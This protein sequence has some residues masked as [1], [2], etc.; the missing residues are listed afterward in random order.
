MKQWTI[1]RHIHDESGRSYIGLTVQTME[2]RWK[3]HICAAKS[4]KGGRWHFPNAI[5]KYG[6][7]AFSHEILQICYSLEEANTAEKFWIWTYDTQNVLR[8][9]NLAKGGDHIPHPIRKNPWNDPEFR[10]KCGANW[11]HLHTPQAKAAWKASVNT[12]ESRAKR[13][14]ISKEALSRPEVLAKISAAAKQTASTK[15]WSSEK[16]KIRM[17]EMSLKRTPELILEVAQKLKGRKHTPEERAKI[18]AAGK[19]RIVSLETRAKLSAAFKGRIVSLETRAK[20]SAA[21]TRS[22]TPELRKKLSII[23]KNRP[24]NFKA[25]KKAWAVNKGKT[26]SLD[27]CA[28]INCDLIT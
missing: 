21:T 5:R 4:A 25:L 12:F 20:L 13:S 10:K 16:E 23:G 26:L 11:I 24:I 14:V 28:K 19:G 27:T 18:S 7:Q 6:S 22:M 15:D 1:Y 2:C 17:Q 8:G 3:N 9:F